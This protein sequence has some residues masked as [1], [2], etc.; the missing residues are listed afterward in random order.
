M[1]TDCENAWQF[2]RT[3]DLFENRQSGRAEHIM[4]DA[5]RKALADLP[6]VIQI[7]R[8]YR[9]PDWQGWSWTLDRERADWFARR[10]TRDGQPKIAVAQT[11][12]AD[13]IALL[14]GRNEREIVVDPHDVTNCRVERLA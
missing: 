3:R 14:N 6:G 2:E 7:Y 1:F 8:G 13:V 10:P 11:R 9:G 12:R 5:E 4:N